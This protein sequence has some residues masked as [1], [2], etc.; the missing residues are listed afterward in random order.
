MEKRSF[1]TLLYSVTASVVAK[2]AEENQWQE[3]LAMERFIRSKVYALLEREE[4][5]LWQYSAC[6]LA[7]LFDEERAG[8]LV[9]PEV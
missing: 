6:M 1:E 3:D 2:I 7:E 9:L 4:T 5:K 8:A